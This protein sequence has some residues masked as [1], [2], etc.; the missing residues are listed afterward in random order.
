MRGV[1]HL[2]PVPATAGSISA[3]PAL[4]DDPLKTQVASRSEYD[5]SVR[6][7]DVLA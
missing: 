1:L 5:G 6:V 4:G 2:D 3:A 7:L